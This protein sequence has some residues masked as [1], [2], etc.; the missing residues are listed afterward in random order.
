[1]VEIGSDRVT[2]GEREKKYQYNVNFVSK[3]L[4]MGSLR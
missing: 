2:L 4:N 1:M 3:A